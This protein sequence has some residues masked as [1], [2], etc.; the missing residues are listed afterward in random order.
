MR[1]YW[2]L[3]LQSMEGIWVQR[4]YVTSEFAKR[5]KNRT[6]TISW[7][8]RP[9]SFDSFFFFFVV[10]L[11]PSD[12]PAGTGCEQMRRGAVKDVV[13]AIKRRIHALHWYCI[14]ASDRKSASTIKQFQKVCDRKKKKTFREW[15][16]WWIFFYLA[17]YGSAVHPLFPYRQKKKNH[18][19]RHRHRQA[20]GDN[21]ADKNHA[22]PKSRG[23]NQKS[24]GP[25]ITWS[26][27][28]QV[29]NLAGLKSRMRQ[30]HAY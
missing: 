11:V 3:V 21:H 27:I 4:P 29:Q 12:Q 24:R 6:K 19:Y 5:G 30:K 25:K 1:L 17:L 9:R 22:V 16:A 18:R 7:T 28:S 8:S 26:K 14:E 15:N 20:I 13:S 10:S 23:K 2:W